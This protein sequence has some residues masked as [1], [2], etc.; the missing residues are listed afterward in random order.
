MQAMIE[1][2]IK[3]YLQTRG[4]GSQPDALVDMEQLKAEAY[5]RG[6]QQAQAAAEQAKE[7]AAGGVS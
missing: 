2:G 5:Q 1:E 3:S 6:Y 4:Q 7:A